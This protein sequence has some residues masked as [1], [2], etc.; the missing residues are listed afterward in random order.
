[1]YYLRIALALL[2]VSTLQ[3]ALGQFNQLLISQSNTINVEFYLNNYDCLSQ[4]VFLLDLNDTTPNQFRL[5]SYNR[6]PIFEVSL[7][8]QPSKLSKNVYLNLKLTIRPNLTTIQS[9]EIVSLEL[10][11]TILRQTFKINATVYTRLVPTTLFNVSLLSQQFTANKNELI[12]LK[13]FASHSNFRYYFDDPKSND[14]FEL[15]Q[16]EGLVKLKKYPDNKCDYWKCPTT[17]LNHSKSCGFT[18]KVIDQSSQGYSS[19]SSLEAIACVFVDLQTNGPIKGKLY[20]NILKQYK[21]L[22]I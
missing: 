1:M 19:W 14:Y 22:L 15:N 12:R 20:D 13:G 10:Q 4:T 11:S 6:H 2:L 8:E 3:P 5:V 9:P 17:S 21:Y 16:F 18:V 7:L